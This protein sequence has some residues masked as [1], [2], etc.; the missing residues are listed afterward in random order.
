VTDGSAIDTRPGSAVVRLLRNRRLG[1]IALGLA[2]GF[3]LAVQWI[4]FERG[5]IPGDAFTYL[6]AGERLNAGH[7][8]YALSPGDRPVDI[9]PPYWTV[10]LVSPPPIAVVFR[11]FALFGDAGA[12]LWWAL[13][14]LSLAASLILLG[15]RLRPIVMAAAIAVLTIPTVY[16]I[17]VGNLNSMVL[18]G[19]ILVW[20]LATR[21]REAAAGGVVAVMSAVKL[22]PAVLVWWLLATGRRRAFLA[23]V[24]GGSIALAVSIV[25]AGF[26][27]HVE[28]LRLLASGTSFAPSPLSLGGMAVYLGMP[29][30]IARWI[31]SLFAILGLATVFALRGRPAWAYGAAIVTMIYGSPS[32][33][34][35]WFVLLYALL[36]PVAWPHHGNH[37][38]DDAAVEPQPVRPRSGESGDVEGGTEAAV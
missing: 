22:T 30:T 37:E 17:G 4:Y 10:P 34:I 25:G 1:L 8:L 24:V 2:L 14:L 5:L 18:L 11:L 28:Y 9:H 33:S 32:V 19:S 35:N 20:R 31:P 29:A 15:R 21:R 12:Y 16:E 38:G 7:Q 27:T 23:A 36:A 3:L 26:D 6:A 13:Q